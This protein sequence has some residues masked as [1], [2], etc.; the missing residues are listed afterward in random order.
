MKPELFFIDE[1][2]RCITWDQEL[3]LQKFVL[4]TEKIHEATGAVVDVP[5]E[6][7]S[8]N[9]LEALNKF[10]NVRVWVKAEISEIRKVHELGCGRVAMEFDPRK[11]ERVRFEKALEAACR[12]GMEISWSYMD[13][14]HCTPEMVDAFQAIIAQG[15]IKRLI[16]ADREGRMEPF[17]TERLFASLQKKIGCEL[18]YHANNSMGLATASVLGALRSGIRHVAVSVGGVAGYP[19]YEEVAMSAK[20]LL[21]IP[22]T[23]SPQLAPLCRDILAQVGQGIPG[24][25]AVIGSDIFAHESGIH[26]DGVIKKSELYEPF[27][28]ESVGLVRRIVIGKHSGRAA[29]D[30]KLRQLGMGIRPAALPGILEKVR[31]ISIRQKGPLSNEQLAQVIREAQ[32]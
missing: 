1:T 22:L 9:I 4:L 28:P 11:E 16:V 31:E 32:L 25:K 6:V 7:F 14:N 3:T 17:A 30:E 18:E 26:V 13:G 27:S 24:N 12:Y 2:T 23:V 21:Q 5:A 15:R 29:I 10:E 20:Y 8:K 19:A